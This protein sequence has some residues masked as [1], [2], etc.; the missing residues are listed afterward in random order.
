MDFQATMSSLRRPLL[1]VSLSQNM[2]LI[3]FHASFSADDEPGGANGW[4]Q[5]LLMSVWYLFFWRVG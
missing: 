1:V 5:S 4:L 2:H 3:R